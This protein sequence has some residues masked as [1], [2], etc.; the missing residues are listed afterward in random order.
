M[1][2]VDFIEH[3]GKKILYEDY[4]GC[5]PE[6]IKPLLEKA[7][8]LIR[9]SAP[10][11]IVALVNVE[12]IRYNR[13]ASAVMKDF[14]KGNTPYIKCSAVVGMDGLKSVIFKGIIAFT[15]RE[16]PHDF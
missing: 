11:S 3:K 2:G 14:V 9:S 7:A 10:A 1:A 13:E 8:G 6:T 4:S 5:N 16:K 15:G 12:N